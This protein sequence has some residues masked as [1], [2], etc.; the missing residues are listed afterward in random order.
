MDKVLFLPKPIHD[1]P[2]DIDVQSRCILSHSG[3]HKQYALPKEIDCR[4]SE[5]QFAIV[6]AW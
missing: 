4:F 2:M 6:D 3:T 1:L 5:E